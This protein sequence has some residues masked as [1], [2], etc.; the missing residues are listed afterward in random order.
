MEAPWL[1]HVWDKR[2]VNQNNENDENNSFRSGCV[3]VRAL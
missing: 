1:I 2:L 3:S